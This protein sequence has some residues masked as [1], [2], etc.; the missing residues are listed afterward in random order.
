MLCTEINGTLYM[1]PQ[2]AWCG[3]RSL[4]AP[5]VVDLMPMMP[6]WVKS[7]IGRGPEPPLNTNCVQHCAGYWTCVTSPSSLEIWKWELREGTEFIQ[8][9]LDNKWWNQDAY[10]CLT[11][12]LPGASQFTW[13]MKWEPVIPK[14]PCAGENLIQSEDDA[15]EE[16]PCREELLS[17]EK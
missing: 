12:F 16:C 15:K 2:M 11:G 9:S 5:M 13:W 3:T 10:V 6:R 1:H 17:N 8:G 4:G 14:V 7:I